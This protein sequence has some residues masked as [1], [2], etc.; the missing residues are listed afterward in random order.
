MSDYRCKCKACK[1]LDPTEKSGYKE[2]CTRYGTYEDPDE[3][4][5]CRAYEST[6][7]SSGCFLTE[8]CCRFRN[9]PDDCEELSTLRTF[10]D[11]VLLQSNWGNDLVQQYYKIA[12]KLV[13]L[14]DQQSDCAE[15]YD[16]IYN[17]INTVIAHIHNNETE[18][19]ILSYLNMICTVQAHVIDTLYP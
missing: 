5:E 3:V 10:R 11:T 8:A 9:L 13:T 15:I 2:Y 4:R 14:I 19:A 12:P 1:H 16:S 6:S 18:S 17:E 7:S